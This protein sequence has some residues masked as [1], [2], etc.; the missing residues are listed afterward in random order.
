IVTIAGTDTIDGIELLAFSD[1]RVVVT[2]DPASDAASFDEARY[3]AANP[4]V[5][6]AV[7]DGSITSGLAHYQ[8]TGQA[9]GRSGASSYSFDETYYLDANPDVAAA[10]SAGTLNSGYQHF[11]IYG[12]SEGRDPNVLFDTAYYLAGNADVAA[13]IEAG[14]IDSAYDHFQSMGAA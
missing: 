6:A 8:Q 1:G 9:E 2:F 12:R 3:L 11:T 10:V 14:Q 13:A 5:A 4:D 7:E